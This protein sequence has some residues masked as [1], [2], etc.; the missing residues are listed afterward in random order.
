MIP[1]ALALAGVALIS[2]VGAGASITPQTGSAG[3]LAIAQ[4]MAS[5]AN[6][7]GASFQTTT[8]GTPAGTSTTVLGG[9]P[10]DGS[11]FGILTTGNVTSV[12]VP[13]SFASTDN[14]GGN[15]R[16]DTDFDVTV[17]KT[18]I[19]V[20]TGANCLTFDFKFLSEEYPFYVGTP[21][22]D[23]FIAELE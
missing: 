13:A 8:G 16:G 14:G 17:L 2:A 12:P 4:A 21:Y 22:N 18:D 19:S 3:S 20:P 23:A 15:A 1:V 6:V 5:S 10:T 9:F 11:G 7:T